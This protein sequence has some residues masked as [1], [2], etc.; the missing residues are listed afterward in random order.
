MELCGASGQMGNNF[1]TLDNPKSPLP[2]YSNYGIYCHSA[3]Y[4]ACGKEKNLT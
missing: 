4:S 3:F 2:D 1:G